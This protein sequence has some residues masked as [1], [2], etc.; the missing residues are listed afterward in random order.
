MRLRPQHRAFPTARSYGCLGRR[1]PCQR[2]GHGTSCAACRAETCGDDRGQPFVSSPG[3]IRERFFVPPAAQPVTV[4]T[5]AQPTAH[6]GNELGDTALVQG[7][8]IPS[9]AYLIFRAY[10]P[11]PGGDAASCEAPSFTSSKVPVTQAG[12][13]RSGVTTVT[14]PG[15][16]YWVESL[17]DRDGQV[18]VAGECGA[19]G[20]TT[21]V[22]G[23]PAAVSVST[24]GVPEVRLGE[25]AHDVATVVGVPASGATVTFQAYRQSGAG[26]SCTDSELEVTTKPVQVSGPGKFVSDD[27]VLSKVSTYYWVETLSAADGSIIGR[28]VC[29]APGESTRVVPVP[30]LVS[31]PSL[32]STPVSLAETGSDA[33]GSLIAAAVA[34]L[35]LVAGGP[36]PTPRARREHRAGR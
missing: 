16:V 34:A 21:V 5:Q 15:N 4:T 9:G 24:T 14:G 32:P 33:T 2:G 8:S 35:F 17:Y 22:E 31:V 6:V 20:E 12:V 10:G 25:P 1:I 18:I 3:D 30:A 23:E 19:P 7:T 27:V 11:E 36:A 29:G 13:Y 26:A 28:G